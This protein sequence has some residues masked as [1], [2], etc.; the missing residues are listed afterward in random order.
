MVEVTFKRQLATADD[1]FP[2]AGQMRR[3]YDER[4]GTRR[5]APRKRF[6][7]DYWHVPDQYTY[8]PTF[9]DEFFRG[10]RMGSYCGGD[11]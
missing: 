10:F 4:L 7:W 1:F 9:A 8:I 2:D 11:S 3:V 6:V 5:A